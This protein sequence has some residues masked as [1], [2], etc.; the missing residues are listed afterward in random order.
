MTAIAGAGAPPRAPVPAPGGPGGP[1]ARARVTPRTAVA[2]VAGRL[3]VAAT[4]AVVLGAI[5][6][7]RPPALATFCV[8]RATTGIPCPLC[9]GT[10]A[11]ARLGRGRVA[12]A[13]AANPFVL[14][15]GLG[16]VLAPTGIWRRL[17]LA[18]RRQVWTLVAVATAAS[19]LWQLGRV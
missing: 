14:L 13:L 15:V 4:G 10:T 11:F 9:G 1:S 7:H 18:S 5:R 16:V 2:G 19:W 8:L 3:A 12:G 6:W 17:A